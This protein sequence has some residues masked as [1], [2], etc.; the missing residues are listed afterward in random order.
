VT[1]SLILDHVAPY[2]DSFAVSYQ[3]QLN[4][5]TGL[6]VRYLHTNGKKLFVQVQTNSQPV[7]DSAM[8]IPTLFS[9]PSATALAALPTIS[10]VVTGNPILKGATIAPRQLPQFA[11]VL[12]SDPNIGKSKYDGVSVSV[13]R[14][15]ARHLS[16]TAAYTYSRTYDNSFN[17][18]F[19]SSL[20]PRRSQDA[21]EF[22]QPQGLDLSHDYSRSIADV[23]HRFVA[24][25]IY[26]VP[27]K[28]RNS[29]VNGVIGG[30]Q[31]GG[32]FQTQS[33]QLVDLQ[34]GIDSNRNGDNA[35][36]RVLIN[37]NGNPNIGTGLVALTIDSTGAV[38][39]FPQ[40]G[41]LR[42]STRAY[43]AGTC[44]GLNP[45]GSCTTIIVQ[46]NARWVQ[47]GFFAKGLE[48]G[49][50]GLAP[51]NAFRTRGWNNT[52]MTFIKNTRFGKEGRYNFQVGAE[53]HNVFNQREINVTGIGAG[54]R[55]FVEP[56]T[57]QFLDY[58]FGVYG[59]RTI[60]MRAKF[61]F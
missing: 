24:S 1:G 15:F 10:T 43:V 49:G 41:S 34:S 58:S 23:P 47:A 2:A 8:V 40:G 59:G 30:W 14:R 7:V 20:N 54:A 22:Y 44:G 48:N 17:E 45:D 25:W 13:N 32:I 19:T 33:G 55:S 50:E 52:D 60:T 61:I 26:E 31:V 35:G 12:T 53:A 11:G 38:K 36:D 39:G 18:L 16:F 51:R 9:L 21:G 56:F 27:F 5:S 29:F 57:Q 46:P 37:P 28:S 6:E 42:T 3:R 4:R